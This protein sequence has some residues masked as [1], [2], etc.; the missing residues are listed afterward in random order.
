MARESYLQ[1]SYTAR[2]EIENI[3]LN[4]GFDVGKKLEI[5]GK[6]D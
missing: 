5:W 1:N 3:R 6:Q 2:L 4:Q